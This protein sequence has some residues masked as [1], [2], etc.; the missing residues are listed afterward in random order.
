M[1]DILY[2]NGQGVARDDA[3]ALQWYRMARRAG[4]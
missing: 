4:A 2:A 3:E 1:L